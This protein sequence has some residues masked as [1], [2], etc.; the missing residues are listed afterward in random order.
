MAEIIRAN[1][2]RLKGYEPSLVISPGGTDCRLWRYRGVPAYS[3]GPSPLTMATVDEWVEIDDFLHVVRT[4]MLSAYD[5]L[6]G[7]K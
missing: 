6:M 5:Y 3:Y 1:V 7:G 2:R 4:H